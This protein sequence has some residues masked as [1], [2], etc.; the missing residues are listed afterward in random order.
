MIKTVAFLFLACCALG[1]QQTLADIVDL[2]TLHP[3]LKPFRT[4]DR[5]IVA[6]K[7]LFDTLRRMKAIAKNPG[8]S[9]V[10]FDEDGREMCDGHDWQQAYIVCKEKITK[11][12][13]YLLTILE[14]SKSPDDR[15]IA[16]YGS[17]YV[18]SV[19]DSFGLLARFPGEPI[20][21]I[22]EDGYNRALAFVRAQWNKSS[23]TLGP[24][25][26]ALPQYSLNLI[27]YA[28]LLKCKDPIDQAQGLWFLREALVVRPQYAKNCLE[29][30]APLLPPLLVAKDATLQHEARAFLSS[31]DKRNR[32]PK[33]EKPTDDEVLGWLAAVEHDLLPPVRRI[34]S[35][36]TD[37]HP[38]KDRDEL[39]RVGREAL[40]ND[41]I[42]VMDSGK[43]KTD[44]FYRGYKLLRL[45]APLDLLPLPLESVI[46]SVN[47]SP[48]TSSK[49]LLELVETLVGK[50]K[51][52]RLLVEFVLKS[53]RKALEFR[54]VSG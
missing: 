7:E 5:N 25:G 13:G 42:G 20:R 11:Q 54:I 39:V 37:L 36:R 26:E 32:A 15:A 45:P 12:A 3:R 33:S 38:G 22:R 4:P 23:G 50:G 31:V 2:D 44:S 49:Q 17:F 35:N 48:V 8:G 24:D 30:V 28:A 21:Q 1:A 18:E 51:L 6:P 27:P 19:D 29:I 41:S 16:A 40:A 34:N 14:E 43:D 53:E 47:G 10:W 46:T 52:D 9:R